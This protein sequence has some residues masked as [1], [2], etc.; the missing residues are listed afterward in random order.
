MDNDFRNLELVFKSTKHVL[1][2]IK[3]VLNNIKNVLNHIEIVLNNIKIVLNHIEMV[4]ND[5]KIDLNHIKNVLN[6]I[7]I[8]FSGTLDRTLSISRVFPIFA[9]PA[10]STSRL[11]S[12]GGRNVCGSTTAR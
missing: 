11:K 4:L 1:I 12:A 8:V 3:I 6:H 9:A 7:E 2:H 10:S 5:I